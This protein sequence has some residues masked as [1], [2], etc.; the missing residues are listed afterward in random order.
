M[1]TECGRRNILVVLG[2]ALDD[3]AVGIGDHQAVLPVEID[4]VLARSVGIVVE[5]LAVRTIQSA[6]RAGAGGVA[7]QAHERQCCAGRDLGKQVVHRSVRVCA[8]RLRSGKN[9]Q[10]AALQDVNAIGAFG[11]DAFAGSPGPL[12]ISRQR[13]EI[14]GPI[15]HD[16]I[17]AGTVP[18]C[19]RRSVRPRHSVGH[20]LPLNRRLPARRKIADQESNCDYRNHCPTLNHASPPK[21]THAQTGLDSRVPRLGAT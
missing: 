6:W 4:A 11:K 12:L 21:I 16:V 20:R 13:A 9:R 1:N 17:G 18:C 10:F 8:A 5:R 14:L 2:P 3:V 7:D 19:L 15:G